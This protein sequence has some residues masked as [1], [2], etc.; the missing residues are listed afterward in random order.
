[1]NVEVS[2]KA[3]KEVVVAENSGIMLAYSVEHVLDA[4][5]AN[6][7]QSCNTPPKD[8]SE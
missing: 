6:P 8:A 5:N 2:G 7:I 3:A 1:V 4:I